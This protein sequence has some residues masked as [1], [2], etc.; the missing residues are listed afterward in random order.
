MPLPTF[1][2]VISLSSDFYA[3]LMKPISLKN[4]L[5][6]YLKDRPAG[7]LATSQSGIGFALFE[8]DP[9]RHRLT[10]TGSLV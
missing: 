4:S 6:Q 7:G 1:F 2:A 3:N 9:A 5:F 8:I 10:G